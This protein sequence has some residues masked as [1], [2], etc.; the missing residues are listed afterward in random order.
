MHHLPAQEQIARLTERLT[1]LNQRYY[2]DAV[3]ETTDEEYDRSLRELQDLEFRYPEFAQANSPTKRVG[4]SVDK[5]FAPYEHSVPMLSLDN[6]YNEAD[7]RDFDQ[8]VRA[9]LEGQAVRYYCELK[10]DGAALSL[11]YQHG[12]LVVAATRGDGVTGENVT[13]NA[14]TIRNL[15]LVLPTDAPE[16]LIVRGEVVMPRKVFAGLNA[17][18]LTSG[19]KLLANPRN[20]AA[21]ALKQQKSAVTAERQLAFYAYGAH[22]SPARNHGAEM[23]LLE[24]Q[25]FEVSWNISARCPTLDDALSFIQH[26]E[27]ARHDFP[28][29]TDGV[30]IKVDD[31]GQREQL[32]FTSKFP[33]WAIAYKFP[34]TAAR[35]KLLDVIY[36]VGRTGA[37]TPVA[38]IEDTPIGGTI[39]SRASLHNANQMA[40]LNLHGGDT[41]LL[42]KGGEIIPKITGVDTTARPADAW[43]IVHPTTC[44]C[45]NSILV[46]EEDEAQHRCVN[47]DCADQQL[48]VIEHFGSR[49]ALA[50]DGLGPELIDRL[51][52]LGLVRSYLDLYALTAE[53]MVAQGIGK[54]TA[55]KLVANIDASKQQPF[56]KVLYALGVRYIGETVSELLA[57]R[58][59]SL[60]G[61]LAASAEDISSIAGIGPSVV[62]SL[63]SW[64]EMAGPV[65]ERLRESGLQLAVVKDPNA[66]EPTT[67]LAGLSFLFSGVFTRP[68]T[69]LED[70]VKSSGGTLISSVSKKLSY[71]V[72]GQNMGPSKREKA[73]TLG[74]KIISETDFL[75]LL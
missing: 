17:A 56:A 48:G 51:Y 23:G 42:E 31:Y 40:A 70:L 46:R 60:D 13:A 30:V 63:L 65:V 27:K 69:E 2:Q 47:S 39:V 66:A 36:Q 3:S 38:V 16:T 49:R 32:G 54:R 8:R 12:Q 37:I 5:S 29:D 14:R 44:P 24:R 41:I 58:F 62:S 59:Q 75:A 33:R 67:Q 74:V 7:L 68:R 4:G 25:G 73:E 26:W 50:I 21:G 15:P 20:A 9:A 55:E 11:V 64:R 28:V 1:Y 35:A 53:A 6:S 71:L 18:R 45:C 43:P 19:E 34:Q 10:Y 22:G 72:A 57:E 61:I 52:G